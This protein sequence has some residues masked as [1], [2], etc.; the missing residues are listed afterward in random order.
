MID[1]TLF[2]LEEFRKA[3]NKIK[4]HIRKT[5]LDYSEYFSQKSG[6]KVYLKCEN[7]QITGSF[8]LRGAMNA[9]LSLSQEQKKKGVV[10]ASAGN[11][12]KAISFCAHLLSLPASI[13]VPEYI[14]KTKIQAIQSYGADLH[15]E[16]KI[17]DDSEL[18]A[19][20]AEKAEGKI[21]ISAYNDEFV[22]AGQG[23]IGLELFEE[24]EH[25]DSILIP[26]SG[27]GLFA[28]VAASVKGLY[29]HIKCYGVQ[30]Q[31]APVMYESFRQGKLV[32]VPEEETIAEVL[33]GGIEEGCI[34]FPYVEKYCEDILLVNESEIKSAL[35]EFISHHKMLCE[36]GSAV[37]LAAVKKYKEKFIGETVVI[38]ITGSNIDFENVQSLLCNTE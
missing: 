10:T 22:I 17:F 3:L 6:A 28:G 1:H 2:T 24:L 27:G 26:I 9:M 5:P 8:K 23:T 35:I 36:G 31:V 25:V 33:T 38:I 30:A 7:L 34:T 21:Y 11:H 18:L 32:N 16:G 14:Q 29:P 4:K 19:R 37:G 12:G 13:Y 20:K 15:I